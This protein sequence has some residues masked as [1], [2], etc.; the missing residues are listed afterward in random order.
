LRQIPFAAPSTSAGAVVWA[1]GGAI[2]INQ[3][4]VFGQEEGMIWASKR[5]VKHLMGFGFFA[6][7]ALT[8]GFAGRTWAAN[9][10]IEINQAKVDAAGGFPYVISAPGAYQLTGNLT[11]AASNTDGIDITA[12]TGV[13]TIQFNDFGIVGTGSGVGIKSTNANT[14]IYLNNGG[15]TGFSNGIQ[16]AGLSTVN[17][18]EVYGNSAVGVVM[19]GGGGLTTTASFDNGSDGIQDLGNSLGMVCT[20]CYAFSN[21]GNGINV[22]LVLSVY[23][24]GVT[25]NGLNGIYAG[26]AS[27]IENSLIGY[28]REA[29]IVTQGSQIMGNS[30]DGNGSSGIALP[31]DGSSANGCWMNRLQF[32]DAPAFSDIASGACAPT[33]TSANVCGSGAG[34][35]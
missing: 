31:A 2:E 30:I 6:I 16:L 14:F 33:G 29:G 4:K 32:N 28:D 12:I 3:A 11:V 18:M 23:N 1:A 35:P 26:G 5:A 10:V 8:I 27:V 9:G 7:V 34:C 19:S 13:V 20:S 15:V 25:G 24:A 22:A 17:N 21:G